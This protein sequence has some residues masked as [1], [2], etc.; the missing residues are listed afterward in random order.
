MSVSLPAACPY[1][2]LPAVSQGR[3][4]DLSLT[5]FPG[6]PLL[7][8]F[9]P[10]DWCDTEDLLELAAA[11]PRFRRAGC[12]LLACSTDSA[13][14]HQQWVAASRAAG[15]LGGQIDLPLLSDRAGLLAGLLGLEC[16]EEGG[17]QRAL[18]LVDER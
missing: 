9:Y 2:P 14:V 16:E 5:D 1:L 12:Q 13:A 7:V 8:F 18:L 10:A 3:V 11:R 6:Q 15:G 17:C 4:R